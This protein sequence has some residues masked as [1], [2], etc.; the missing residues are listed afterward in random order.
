MKLRIYD[1]VYILELNKDISLVLDNKGDLD[2]AIMDFKN[3][4]AAI[5]ED[6]LISPVFN[7]IKTID[8]DLSQTELEKTYEERLKNFRLLDLPF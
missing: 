4:M 5:S 8:V 2:A 6:W 3:G 7:L 1:K